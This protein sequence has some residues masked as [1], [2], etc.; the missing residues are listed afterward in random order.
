MQSHSSD[1]KKYETRCDTIL[2]TVLLQDSEE[3]LLSL[4]MRNTEKFSLF[5]PLAQFVALV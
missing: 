2:T 3:S 4:K 5:L 1:N